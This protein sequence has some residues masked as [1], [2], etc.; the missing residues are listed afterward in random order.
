[1]HVGMMEATQYILTK[2]FD[3]IMHALTK[4]SSA[5]VDGERGNVGW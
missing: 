5:C 2:I 4:L 3:I 1:M